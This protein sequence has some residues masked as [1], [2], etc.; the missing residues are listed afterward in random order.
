MD[1]EL[2][3]K[4]IIVTGASRGLGSAI[5]KH[6]IDEG[7]CVVAAARSEGRVPLTKAAREK[8]SLLFAHSE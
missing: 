7:A 2:E 8:S 4:V 1:L 5:A 6:L 3:D